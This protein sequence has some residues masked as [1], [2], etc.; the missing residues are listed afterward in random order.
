MGL[1]VHF[2]NLV[3]EGICDERFI[4]RIDRDV[5]HSAEDDLNRCFTFGWCDH[6]AFL[7][8]G[9]KLARDE[10]ELPLRID[11][12]DAIPIH[13]LDAPRCSR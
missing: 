13:K 2:A 8:V 9:P 12:K 5:M 7:A 4:L 6:R 11:F 10:F 1:Q 3:S